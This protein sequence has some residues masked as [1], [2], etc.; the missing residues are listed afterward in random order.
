MNGAA[1]ELVLP[2]AVD[3][4]ILYTCA[5]YIFLFFS[6]PLVRGFRGHFKFTFALRSITHNATR[7]PALHY[8]GLLATR[9]AM[10]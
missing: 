7:Y 10:C 1:Q 9:V 4:K 6:V 3:F 5:A 2:G 8:A